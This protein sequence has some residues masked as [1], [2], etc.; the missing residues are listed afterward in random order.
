MV[1]L[2]VSAQAARLIELTN[3]QMHKNFDDFIRFLSE[4]GLVKPARCYG[5]AANATHPLNRLG[6]V[7]FRF[8]ARV[9]SEREAFP[10]AAWVRFHQFVQL[11]H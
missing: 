2:M 4:L 11:M 5:A 6:K 9:D 8:T 1:I 7:G 3:A 10:I